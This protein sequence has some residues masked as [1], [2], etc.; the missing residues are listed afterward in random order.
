MKFGVQF[1]PCVGPDQKSADVYFHECLA[2]AELGE[3]IGYTHFRAVEHYF[4]PYG[5][6][7]PNPLMFLTAIA[8]RTKNAR[9]ITGAVLPVF[10]HPLKI[11]GEIGMLDAISGG[12]L[13]VG[14]ARAFLPHEFRQ[15]G[16]SPDES[17]ARFREG[18]EQIRL[19]LTKDNASSVG[20]F[21]SFKNVT[22]LPKATQRPHPPFYVAATQTAETFE[23]AGRNGLNL[24]AIP[25]GNIKPL[26]E[27][28]RKSWRDAE[29]PG[30][31]EVMVAFHMLC[32]HNGADARAVAKAPFEEYFN[33]L[34]EASSDWV[35]GTQSKDYRDYDKM[36]AKM[37]S[38]N[39][40]NQIA[41]GGAW[42]GSPAE[43]RE[44]I[45]NVVD[46]IGPFE[47]ASL[48]VNFGSLPLA[49]A[50]DSMRLFANEVMGHFAN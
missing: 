11:A 32:Q 30:N 31:G 26:L 4:H 35:N 20:D 19:L 3:Q 28:Y 34:V 15:F 36:M 49:T 44:T 43:I 5:G 10:N 23:Y 29:H 9:L 45:S 50:A 2:L 7:S 41:T 1:F 42:I 13:D 17:Q 14:F 8:M 48:Q 24:M 21:H 47:H 25:I 38:V 16:I 18:I 6:Y 27:L 39:L 22:S 46:V 33:S 12:R 37:K 40:D